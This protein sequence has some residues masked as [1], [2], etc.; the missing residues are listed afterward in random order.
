[1]TR[2]AV[3]LYKSIVRVKYSESIGKRFFLGSDVLF[4]PD[5]PILTNNHVIE[6]QKSGAVF[7]AIEVQLLNKISEPPRAAPEFYPRFEVC[8]DTGSGH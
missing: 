8:P 5:R 7:G 1:M 6:D 2:E 4:S 3:D